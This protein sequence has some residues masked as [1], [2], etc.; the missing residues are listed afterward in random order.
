MKY[1][2]T[3]EDKDTLTK[4]DYSDIS[5]YIREEIDL[6]VTKPYNIEHSLYK[7]GD[8]I[9]S[10]FKI[11]N[12]DVIVSSIII[13]DSDT[14]CVNGGKHYNTLGDCISQFGVNTDKYLYIGF[15]EYLDG[16]YND[17]K[18]VNDNSTLFRKMTTIIEIIKDMVLYHKINYIIL[19]SV[20]NDIESGLK[21]NY[22]KRDKF[23]ELFLTYHK[24]K[25]HKIK[26]NIDING[27]IISNFFILEV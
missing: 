5:L 24:V 12:R 17:D 1:I 15:G 3:F 27:E 18:N 20:D 21:K 2:K 25:Y 26:P 7:S 9:C 4:V 23:Y 22:K 10:S 16:I 13:G 6:G 11:G 19:N 8:Y 14:I